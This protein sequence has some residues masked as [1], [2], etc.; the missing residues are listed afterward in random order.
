MNKFS[1][2]KIKTNLLIG[3]KIKVEDVINLPIEIHSFKISPSKHSKEV[4][5]NCLYLQIRM[6]EK[7]YVLF[8]GSNVLMEQIKKVP[9]NGFPFLG[10]IVKSG[11]CLQFKD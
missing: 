4:G 5:D 3:D 7:D 10:R 9:E 8:T 2:F 6:H 11:R 1:D